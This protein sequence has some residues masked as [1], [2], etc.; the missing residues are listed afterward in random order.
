MVFTQ[1]NHT[2]DN[3]FT[4]LR[5]WGADVA[6]GWPTQPNP[7]AHG[8]AHTRAAY[9]KWL[10][11][12]ASGAPTLAVHTQIDTD[13]VLPYYAWLAKTGA[14]LRGTPA[15]GQAPGGGELVRFGQLVFAE[16]H[17]EHFGTGRCCAAAPG[18]AVHSVSSSSS[19]PGA[20]N[21]CVRVLGR[22]WVVCSRGFGREWSRGRVVSRWVGRHRG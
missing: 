8:H 12:Q 20:V 1:E 2:T 14:F 4:A 19:W 3:Y 9:A 17:G 16:A 15:G 22:G 7:P 11:V 5:A 10:H 13:T 18:W 21:G 6:T